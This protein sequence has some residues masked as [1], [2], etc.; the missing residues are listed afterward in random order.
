MLSGN[1]GNG[2]TVSNATAVVILGNFIGTDATGTHALGNAADGVLLDTAAS[3]MIGGTAAGARNII[4]GNSV[5][6]V[7]I[8]RRRRSISNLVQGN[9]IGS[10]MTGKASLANL[11]G[12]F[13]NG[14]V[15]CDRRSGPWR[16]A[17]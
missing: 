3:N 5:A 6:G 9:Y 14:A 8:R 12:V 16:R 4:S 13:L 11:V 17:I 2:V 7:E 1:G 10:G 15:K